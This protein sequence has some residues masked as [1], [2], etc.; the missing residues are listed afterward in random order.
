MPDFSDLQNL[1]GL[2]GGIG[3]VFAHG[4]DFCDS[5]STRK[6]LNK[7]AENVRRTDK[8]IGGS[9]PAVQAELASAVSQH[10]EQSNTRARGAKFSIFGAFCNLSNAGI[11]T[12]IAGL[13]LAGNTSNVL[14][15]LKGVASKACS[16]IAGTVDVAN[17]FI[18]GSTLVSAV[19]SWRHVKDSASKDMYKWHA[20]NQAMQT[21]AT[22]GRGASSFVYVAGISS[23]P[24]GPLGP[25]APSIIGSVAAGIISFLSNKVCKN[26]IE[27]AKQRNRDNPEVYKTSLATQL[28]T[29]RAEKNIKKYAAVKNPNDPVLASLDEENPPKRSCW[30]KCCCCCSGKKQEKAEAAKEQELIGIT[31]D[32]VSPTSI[33]LT[34][35][36]QF[37]PT[38]ISSPD[39]QFSPPSPISSPVL[40]REIFIT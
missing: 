30:R 35:D 32:Q 18:Q 29:K 1:T 11:N 20:I 21:I 10:I 17:G 22:W 19:R 3:S 24:L 33:P 40:Q 7:N 28:S 4:Y 39:S 5:N 38:P 26:R 13:Q 16:G 2:A 14:T 37:S 8:Q 6:R 9:Q 31:I 36:S 12:A 25:V 15:A 27:A 34:A 23:I